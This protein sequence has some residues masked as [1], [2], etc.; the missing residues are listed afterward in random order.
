MMTKFKDVWENPKTGLPR[1][2][3]SSG[4]YIDEDKKIIQKIINNYKD[5][6]LFTKYKGEFVHFGY[7]SYLK[8]YVVSG[9]GL[10]SMEKFNDFSKMWNYLQKKYRD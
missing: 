10:H 2:I 8:S 5:E 7:D 4:K 6:F 9:A 3:D 1:I